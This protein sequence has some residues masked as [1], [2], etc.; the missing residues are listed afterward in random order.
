MKDRLLLISPL[1]T[2]YTAG[3]LEIDEQALNSEFTQILNHFEYLS[4]G[5]LL[6]P[7]SLRETSENS[8]WC[9][10]SSS[11]LRDRLEIIPLPYAYKLTDFIASFK[12]TRNLLR[13]EILNSK[14]LAFSPY[15]LIGDWAGVACLE[16]M[17]L[18]RSYAFMIAR[19]EYEILR[20]TARTQPLKRR[21]KYPIT[22]NLMKQYIRFVAS[23][24]NVALLQ[25]SD[26]FNEFSPY[27]KN[28]HLVHKVSTNKSDQIEPANLEHKLASI[29]KGDDLQICYSGRLSEM[30]GPLDW[31]R[32]IH[33]ALNSG[34]K[35]KATWLGDGSL[36]NDALSLAKEL[37]VDSFI[38]F[39]GFVSD[40]GQVLSTLLNSHLFMFCHKT[41]ESARCLI[42]ALVSGC[43]IVGY[44]SANS[45]ELVAEKGGGQFVPVNDW[46]KLAETII[47]LDRD[48]VKLAALVRQA[49]L[50][51]R[52]FDQE[53]IYH[54]RCSLIQQYGTNSV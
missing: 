7:E 15:V 12:Q 47:A 37:A 26:C 53:S 9:K 48:R 35:L 8:A 20:K 3:E 6:L 32:A 18:G 31:I 5:C 44:S 25:G 36:Q 51:G 10:V 49:A 45:D 29:I 16:A 23:R 21:I 11:P 28:P 38:D 41:P 46:R 27:C 30:K 22:T 14:Y 19:I 39:P 40:R 43:A 33:L 1:P 13:Q 34:V 50:S 42:E 24:S 54:Y 4:V 17:S 52:N 2:R